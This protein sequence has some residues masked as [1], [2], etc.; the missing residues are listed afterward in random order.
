MQQQRVGPATACEP[1]RKEPLHK[2]RRRACDG[3]AGHGCV[4]ACC[5]WQWCASQSPAC[6]RA[7]AH[8]N[9]LPS[10]SH[11]RQG[12]MALAPP[13]TVTPKG[14]AASL[15]GCGG[16]GRPVA[17]YVRPPVSLC[18]F[19]PLIILCRSQLRGHA[20][21]SR[22]SRCLSSP[23]RRGTDGVR[24]AAAGQVLLLSSSSSTGPCT[25]GASEPSDSVHHVLGSAQQLRWL[26]SPANDDLEAPSVP[27]PEDWHRHPALLSG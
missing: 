5:R 20:S 19:H 17:S 6:T 14:L 13:V 23:P 27:A 16:L 11:P 24:L 1:G 12:S 18:D 25:V 8:E 9:P 10:A 21:S 15:Q 2:I 3:L 7:S 22:G 4:T 26:P